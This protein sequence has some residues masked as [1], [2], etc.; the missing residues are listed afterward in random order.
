VDYGKRRCDDVG[1]AR[2]ILA[3]AERLF[4]LHNLAA[5][6]RRIHVNLGQA[7]AVHQLLGL[8]QGVSGLVGIARFPKAHA[9]ADFVEDAFPVRA[10]VGLHF[11]APAKI[12]AAIMTIMERA[13]RHHVHLSTRRGVRAH[14]DTSAA[15]LART[16]DAE[17]AVSRSRARHS[18]YSGNGMLQALTSLTSLPSIFH[19]SPQCVHRPMQL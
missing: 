2:Q 5:D 4:G 19:S 16:M 17:N 11:D 7:K 6:F 14:D 13:T 3:P 10:V 12:R 1:Q 18:G 8:T 15:L 9:F